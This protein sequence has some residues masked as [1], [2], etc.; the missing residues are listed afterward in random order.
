MRQR[1]SKSFS[2]GR[3]T[4]AKEVLHCFVL[5]YFAVTPAN[6]R[7]IEDLIDALCEDSYA[8][9]EKYMQYPVID[10]AVEGSDRLT[11][12]SEYS[13]ELN[14]WGRKIQQA[15]KDLRNVFEQAKERSKNPKITRYTKALTDK[16]DKAIKI[17]SNKDH[18][19]KRILN[20]IKTK[21]VSIQ[22]GT[23]GRFREKLYTFTAYDYK[24]DKED[25]A[26]KS[27]VESAYW[28]A[29]A[30]G[31]LISSY[32]Q[33]VYVHST[34]HSARQIKEIPL[35]VIAEVA[36]VTLDLE[37]LKAD[38]F[39]PADIYAIK[40]KSLPTLLR[41]YSNMM[42][43]H[44]TN[45]DNISH[46]SL[47]IIITN[48]I[49]NKLCIPI[50]LKK[51]L[52][53]N[54]PVKLIGTTNNPN[55]DHAPLIDSYTHVIEYLSTGHTQ[56]STSQRAGQRIQEMLSK[57]IEIKKIDYKHTIETFSVDFA[58][59]YESLENKLGI[60]LS[61]EYYKL[62]TAS[63]TWNALP[64]DSKGTVIGAYT[65]GAGF[66][67]I[68]QILLK[69]PRTR[70]IF[71][72]ITEHRRTA[73]TSALVSYVGDNIKLPA[74]LNLNQILNKKT[75][76]VKIEHSIEQHLKQYNENYANT[77]NKTA[78]AKNVYAMYLV[79]LNSLLLY[80]RQD[81]TEMQRIT[82]TLIEFQVNVDNKKIES[83][84]PS[85]VLK[86]FGWIK[87][88]NTWTPK[89]K[90]TR[91][92]RIMIQ[93]YAK[94][95]YQE[96]RASK[97]EALYFYTEGKGSLNNGSYTVSSNILNDFY[98][99]QITMTIYGLITK[100]QSKIFLTAP[101]VKEEKQAGRKARTISDALGFKTTPYFIIG[102]ASD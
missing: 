39:N 18:D 100:K 20:K 9:Y 93:Q 5:A 23:S 96:D 67:Q 53:P 86:S 76:R 78:L 19:L 95:A 32:D 31:S 101:E 73:F 69:Y 98:K 66:T 51:S 37:E 56:K 13:T 72:E 65:G 17:L 82:T 52:T 30:V 11:A 89:A 62:V 29:E 2:L 50:S 83:L 16:R 25:V 94:V 61:N 54:P 35:S 68:S 77:S 1:Y 14:E 91:S 75:D 40:K 71:D 4:T 10:T 79:I 8:K 21:R 49:R 81:E 74:I 38:M 55:I 44:Y 36:R 99:K 42:I 7:S 12:V 3:D 43:K 60:Q 84:L 85:T 34:S 102:N 80:S 59:N 41:E 87:K 15:R 88:S 22:K 70:K 47:H 48:Q 26:A 97:L 57:L 45:T 33:Y 6:Q 92:E 64:S 24:K 27:W 63:M 46:T 28:N 90:Q 58:L